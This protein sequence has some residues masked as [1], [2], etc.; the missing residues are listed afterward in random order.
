ML[1]ATVVAQ[2]HSTFHWYVQPP[3]LPS[4]SSRNGA[5][6]EGAVLHPEQEERLRWHWLEPSISWKQSLQRV[7]GLVDDRAVIC[8]WTVW[9]CDPNVSIREDKDGSCESTVWMCDPNASILDDKAL[10]CSLIVCICESIM[11]LSWRCAPVVSS[12]RLTVSA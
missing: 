3:P 4:V 7:T 5:V 2:A 9:T 6:H 11:R 8:D 10:I 1:S 12:R